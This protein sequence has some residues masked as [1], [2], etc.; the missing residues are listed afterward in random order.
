MTRHEYPCK[1]SF[2]NLDTKCI[3]VRVELAGKTITYVWA[4]WTD[5]GVL[6]FHACSS[7]RLWL[8]QD[9]LSRLY[10]IAELFGAHT[11][12]TTP[13]GENA[14]MIRRLLGRVGFEDRGSFLS[15]NLE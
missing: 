2:E 11:L 14:P 3:K 5:D 15:L 7:R 13:H 4:N 12:T 8:T 6:D 1:W 9:V 10:V